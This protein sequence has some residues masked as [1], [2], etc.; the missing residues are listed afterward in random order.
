[1]QWKTKSTN[2][3]LQVDV[4]GNLEFDGFLAYTVKVT[5]LKDV[6]L[7]DVTMHIPFNKTA[8]TYMMGLWRK[9]W[10]ERPE[11]VEWKWDVATK[12]KMV[13]GLAM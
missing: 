6:A 9:R 5:A 7:K 3:S 2:D 4:T 8:A 12:I 11:K 10:I 13:H 1:V